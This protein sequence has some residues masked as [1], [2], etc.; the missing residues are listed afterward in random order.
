MITASV[1]K[2]LKYTLY[3]QSL[4]VETEKTIKIDYVSSKF[5]FYMLNIVALLLYQS[6]YGKTSFLLFRKI[7]F[8]EYYFVTEICCVIS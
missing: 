5:I 7:L 4:R 3:L 2:E 1:M 6:F 8:L